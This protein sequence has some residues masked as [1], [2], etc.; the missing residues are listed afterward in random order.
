MV[1]EEVI[2]GQAVLSG[3]FSS[4]ELKEPLLPGPGH[5]LVHEPGDVAGRPF[6]KYSTLATRKPCY[7]GRRARL[8]KQNVA[9][10]PKG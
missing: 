7:L 5:P 9:G 4:G 1:N 8:V 10:A 3:G 6:N 2:V